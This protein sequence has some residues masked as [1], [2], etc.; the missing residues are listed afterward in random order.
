MELYALIKENGKTRMV[1]SAE[2]DL[3]IE[4]TV[5]ESMLEIVDRIIEKYGKYHMVRI[6]DIKNIDVS[7]LKCGNIAIACLE[8]IID[9]QEPQ[10]NFYNDG[11]YIFYNRYKAF[12]LREFV[13]KYPVNIKVN[14][15]NFDYILKEFGEIKVIDSALNDSFIHRCGNCDIL[16]PLSCE[17]AE[18]IKRKIFD[19]DF[20]IDGFQIFCVEGGN[21]YL[22]KFI[23][24]RCK[25]YAASK[26][27]IS[28]YSSGKEGKA[29]VKKVVN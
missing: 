6:V 21:E 23:V 8:K 14:R 7:D 13:L 15:T 25:N 27:D 3:A 5:R 24:M 12:T 9:Y 4:L 11:N 10:Y 28:Y 22:D 26:Q 20:I 29:M 1:T 17:K 2:I 18:Y 19:Y 16:S